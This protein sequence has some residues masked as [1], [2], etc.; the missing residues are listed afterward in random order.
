VE[1]NKSLTGVKVDREA[2]K[3]EKEEG[4]RKGKGG[5]CRQAR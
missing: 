3:E 5:F 2:R 4:R 1:L